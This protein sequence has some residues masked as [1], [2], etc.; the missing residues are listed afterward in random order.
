MLLI[1]YSSPS[2]AQTAIGGNLTSTELRT[3][4]REANYPTTSLG[5]NTARGPRSMVSR[6]VVLVK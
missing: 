2:I 3:F 6:R 4:L 5:Y 1:G